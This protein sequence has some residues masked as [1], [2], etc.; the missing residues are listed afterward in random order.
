[1]SAEAGELEAT[2]PQ[3]TTPPPKFAT[4]E[5]AWAYTVE[6]LWGKTG[7]TPDDAGFNYG[8]AVNIYRRVVAKYPEQREFADAQRFTPEQPTRADILAMDAPVWV[9]G[10]NESLFSVTD[11]AHQRLYLSYNGEWLIDRIGDDGSSRTAILEV[12]TVLWLT[13]NAPSAQAFVAGV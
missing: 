7:L 9:L 8:A 1:M 11:D 2:L 10:R 4:N 12:D 3:V 6:K 13:R 5:W